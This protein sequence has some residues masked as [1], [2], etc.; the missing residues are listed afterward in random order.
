MILIIIAFVF[1]SVSMLSRVVKCTSLRPFEKIAR[2][3]AMLCAVGIIILCYHFKNSGAYKYEKTIITT[4]H[5]AQLVADDACITVDSPD[6]QVKVA[7]YSTTAT[8]Y[9]IQKHRYHIVAITSK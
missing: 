3:I 6:I 5:D 7:V 2:T 1:L 8:W 4:L 9:R